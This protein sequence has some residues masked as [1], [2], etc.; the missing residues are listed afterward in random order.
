LRAVPEKPTAGHHQRTGRDRDRDRC[1]CEDL[2][3]LVQLLKQ[4]RQGQ[5][6]ALGWA[7]RLRRSRAGKNVAVAAQQTGTVARK[8]PLQAPSQA[9]MISHGGGEIINPLFEEFH[10]TASAAVQLN[11]VHLPRM[12]SPPLAGLAG[13]VDKR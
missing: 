11:M 13:A 8:R 6:W 10:T 9:I 3:P 7:A 4:L 1:L 12:T 2:K 5:V